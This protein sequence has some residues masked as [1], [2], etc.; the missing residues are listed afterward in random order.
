MKRLLLAVFLA[1]CSAR[2]ASSEN[3]GREETDS[4]RPSGLTTFA[5]TAEPEAEALGPLP[6]HA[7]VDKGTLQ[8]SVGVGTETECTF[9][10]SDGPAVRD[11]SVNGG[12]LALTLDESDTHAWL[13]GGASIA[14]EGDQPLFA[15]SLLDPK[16]SA[17]KVD[18]ALDE[19]PDAMLSDE[20]TY[21]V[22]VRGHALEPVHDATL[23]IGSTA[24]AAKI[25][26]LDD[27]ITHWEM[28]FDVS[29]E[30]WVASVLHGENSAH[31]LAHLETKDVDATVTMGL[32]PR[33]TDASHQPLD[34]D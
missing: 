26:K 34:A 9:G 19:G 4:E 20:D 15:W 17:P 14:C 3:P 24:Y 16:V 29:P 13:Y 2:L 30:K 31:L 7:R 28:T 22:R 12:E 11:A 6:I 5:T 21:V 33:V 23:V 27:E 32:E 8:V 25:A 10:Q 18:V 1:G